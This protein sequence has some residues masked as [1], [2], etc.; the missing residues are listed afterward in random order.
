M[1]FYKPATESKVSVTKLNEPATVDFLQT[2]DRVESISDK[3]K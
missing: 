3:V 2:G 1:T